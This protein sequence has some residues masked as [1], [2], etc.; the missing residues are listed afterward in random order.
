MPQT[1]FT[2]SIEVGDFVH[3]VAAES[4]SPGW[5][6]HLDVWWLVVATP[7]QAPA[8][9]GI[10]LE[11]WNPRTGTTDRHRSGIP[12]EIPWILVDER[13]GDRPS[14][15]IPLIPTFKEGVKNG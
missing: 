13:I 1:V 3:T 5:P 4:M 8:Y 9:Y 2:K 6:S 7:P 10:A 12:H 11:C 14:Q 15:G